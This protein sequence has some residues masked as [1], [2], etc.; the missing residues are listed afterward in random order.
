MAKIPAGTKTSKRVNSMDS[1]QRPLEMASSIEAQRQ[2][3][4]E[5][6]LVVEELCRGTKET[7]QTSQ[8]VIQATKVTKQTSKTMR[9]DTK[10]MK[11]NAE[12]MMDTA[13]VMG[14]ASE[15]IRLANIEVCQ[16]LT[17]TNR[18]KL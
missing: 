16:S 2:L 18:S 14:Q 9:Q 13:K 7:R 1:Q 15:R 6:Q 10:V 11:D 3:V 5:H 4:K 12:A 8:A 17:P